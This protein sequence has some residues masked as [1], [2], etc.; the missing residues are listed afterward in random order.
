M[1]ILI[2]LVALTAVGDS[3]PW[4][5]VTLR[6]GA[7]SCHVKM[8]IRG[9]PAH[10]AGLQDGD[11]IATIDGTKV[12]DCAALK[13]RLKGK[14]QVVL[15]WKRKSRSISKGI[16]LVSMPSR[17][18]I[19]KQ[20]LVSRT[21]LEI[22]GTSMVNGQPW[23]L[24]KRH[25]GVTIIQF[26][27]TWCGACKRTYAP[28][29]KAAAKHGFKVVGVYSDTVP[30]IRELIRDH[31]LGYEVVHDP[32]GESFSRYL[33]DAFPTVVVL[34]QKGTISSVH[35]GASET[36]QAIASALALVGKKSVP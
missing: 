14:S 32:Q 12:T 4:L 8:V 1:R 19:L 9:T 30:E 31:Q 27:A 28:L 24:K 34:N 15:Q 10:G 26:A 11:Q 5:G 3:K 29:E 2:L 21:P 36:G 13:S 18:D 33:V 25:P 22:K 17:L 35:V 7:S 20:H 23:D 16:K 6:E